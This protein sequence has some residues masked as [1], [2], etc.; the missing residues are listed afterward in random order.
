MQ[1]KQALDYVNSRLTFGI[2]PGLERIKKLLSLMGD[3]QNE[4]KYVHVAGTN[5]KGSTCTIISSILQNSGYC[6]G[7][8]TSPFVVDFRERFKFNFKMIEKEEFIILIERIK[9]FVNIMEQNKDFITEFELITAL[10]FIWFKEKNCDIVVLEVGLGGTY[11]ATNVIDKALVSVITSISM[12]HTNI[13][14]D[15]LEKIAENKAGII[16]KDGITV[17]YPEQDSSVMEVLKAKATLLNNKIVIPEL[18]SISFANFSREGS[19]FLYK[20][21]KYSLSLIGPHQ[22]KNAI[23]AIEV[24]IQLKELGFKISDKNIIKGLENISFASRLEV[25]SQDPY[26]LIDGAH[27]EGGAIALAETIN[28][29]FSGKKIV[30]IMGMLKDKD[31]E[32]ILSLLAPLFFKIVITVPYNNRAMNS[33]QLKNIAIK[34]CENIIIKE[35][36]DQAADEAL[37]SLKDSDM[38]LICGSL[39]LSGDIRKIIIKK[40]KK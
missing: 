6:V 4:L 37:V 3:P 9:P 26:I 23:T 33:D 34:Y 17:I 30:A 2:K 31:A 11:D 14:G 18:A 39:Y 15:T 19:R 7:L 8:F 22:I 16:K 28:E 29:V 21:V 32:K 5:G 24:V 25:L 35:N 27:N 12:D 1:Y 38:I 36:L 40:L 10:A 13:L 20:G